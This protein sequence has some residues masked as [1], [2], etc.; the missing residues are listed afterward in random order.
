MPSSSN[1]LE[2]F[3]CDAKRKIKGWIFVFFKKGSL[4]ERKREEAGG[5]FRHRVVGTWRG[6]ISSC[7]YWK[8][9]SMGLLTLL[10]A[11]LGMTGIWGH[12][13][14]YLTHFS[15]LCFQ[16]AT[17]RNE[18]RPTSR[19]KNS[20]VYCLLWKQCIPKLSIPLLH[21]KHTACATSVWTSPYCPCGLGDSGNQLQ[22]L[23][24]M[25][26]ACHE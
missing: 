15:G 25:L 17:F 23:I 3:E 6:I 24:S 18:G 2:F 1:I 19:M 14:L 4:S 9:S 21:C 11:L 26:L 5:I 10:H 22:T 12:D 8:Q 16:W 13:P 20:L 7:Y